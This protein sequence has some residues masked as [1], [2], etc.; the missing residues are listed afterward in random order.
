MV[1]LSTYREH[2]SVVAMNEIWIKK[3][4]TYLGKVCLNFASGLVTFF[5]VVRLHVGD[6]NA[7]G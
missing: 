3:S 7:V 5:A 2:D 4:I 1:H 6:L